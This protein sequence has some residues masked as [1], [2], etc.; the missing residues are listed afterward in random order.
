M[1]VLMCS[2]FDLCYNSKTTACGPELYQSLAC[3]LLCEDAACRLGVKFYRQY[4]TW[5]CSLRA[6][7]LAETNRVSQ[8]PAG[9]QESLHAT[10]LC[11]AKLWTEQFAELLPRV[12]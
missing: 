5:S 11:E 3:N 12:P 1:D 8:N 7:T 6:S 4:G 10:Q 2:I 9:H